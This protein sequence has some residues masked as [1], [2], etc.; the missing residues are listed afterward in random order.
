MTLFQRELLRNLNKMNTSPI[1][2]TVYKNIC[3]IYK[4]VNRSNRVT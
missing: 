3:S 1:I 2:S 4:I